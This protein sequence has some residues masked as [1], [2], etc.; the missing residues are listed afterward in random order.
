MSPW[1]RLARLLQLRG[2]LRG[3]GAV[4]PLLVCGRVFRVGLE[5][6]FAIAGAAGYKGFIPVELEGEGDSITGTEKLVEESPKH[7]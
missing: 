1:L 5:R 6:T 4:S 2:G 3:N 7:L